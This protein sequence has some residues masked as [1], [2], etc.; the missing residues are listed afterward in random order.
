MELLDD[1]QEMRKIDQADML[2]AISSVPEHYLAAL[3][4]VKKSSL[5]EFLSKEIAN[6]VIAGVGGSAIGG[7]IICNWVERRVGLPIQVCRDYHLPAYANRRTAVIAISYSG[8]TAETLNQFL[9]AYERNCVLAGVCSGGRLEKICSELGIPLVKVEKGLQPRAALP[10][11]FVAP[12]LLMERLGLIENAE[13]EIKSAVENLRKIREKVGASIPVQQNPAKRLALS[14]VGKF[15][16]I[17]SLRR[18]DSVARRL[19]NQFNEN[20]KVSAKVDFLPEASHNEIEGWGKALNSV[21]SIIFV[22]DNGESQEEISGIEE[23]KSLLEKSGISDMNEIRGEAETV[24]GRLL[25]A[26]YYCDYVSYYLAIARGV[27]PT[28][29]ERIQMLKKRIL[30]RTKFQETL[31]ERMKELKFQRS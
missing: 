5:E 16:I 6:C 9:E 26:I 19:K 17:Y 2:E 10:Y 12:A 18:V 15:P 21:F 7:D 8:E 27:D 24:L 13:R 30:E 29:V 14:L 31:D 22:R 11:L 4:I 1:L 3:D 20:S 28:P 23:M 25:S